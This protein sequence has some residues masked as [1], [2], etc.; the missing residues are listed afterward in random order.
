MTIYSVQGPDGRIYDIE[1]PEGASE[2]Q[3]IAA[4]QR[5][6]GSQVEAPKPQPKAGFMPN[7][8]AGIERIKGDYYAGLAALG[9]PGAAEEAAAH[10]KKAGEIAYTPEFTEHPLDF[11]TSV[12]GGS[13]PYM[14]AP[15]AAGAAATPLGTLGAMGAAGLA[16]GL[17]FTGS[18][19]SRQLE[20]GTRPEALSLGA[21]AAAAVPQAALDVIGFRYIPGIRTLFAKAGVPLTNEAAKGI[22]GKYI[23]PAAKTAGVEGA[24]EAGQAV[25]ERL[26]AGLSIT[27]PEA[28]K[29]YFD[30]FV[31]GAVLGGALAVPGTMLEGR[32]RPP[33]Q[34]VAPPVEAPV[35]RERGEITTI[36][37]T[38]RGEIGV[39]E[40]KAPAEEAP[41][42][43]EA[44][45]LGYTPTPTPNVVDLMDQY[46]AAQP[47]ISALEEQLQEAAAAG[48]TAN[49]T[50]FQNSL[51]SWMRCK[52][53][54]LS[55]K[56]P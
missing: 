17:Q 20:E 28:R 30:N 23:L 5:H 33:E 11:L 10:R 52:K 51:T 41:A 18:D 15:L 49:S 8:K 16:S 26:Q 50:R 53:N 56:K 12:A 37:P 38:E 32:R 7:V 55:W 35:E 25:F 42:A 21:A 3:I 43:Q 39:A 27:D 14:A 22:V 54:A 2:R 19:L 45:Q 46:Q 24:T 47:R 48:D 13:V 34:P 29:E 6:L 40:Y 44:I 9:R 1:G 4:L 31:G 36:P